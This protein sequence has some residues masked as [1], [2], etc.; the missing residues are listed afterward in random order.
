M[1]REAHPPSA[2]SSNFGFKRPNFDFKQTDRQ[3]DGQTDGR[4][5]RRNKHIDELVSYRQIASLEIS[6][7]ALEQMDLWTFWKSNALSPPNYFIAA[8]TVAL[9]PP[10][11]AVCERLFAR[12]VMGFGDDQ[13]SA[14]EDYKAASTIMRFNNSSMKSNGIVPY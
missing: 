10:S 1:V 3:T 5:D 14:M 6:K 8:C 11:S 2:S 12:L 4:T 13:E 7:P 9:V